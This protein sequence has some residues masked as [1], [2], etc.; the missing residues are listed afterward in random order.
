MA[1]A[2]KRPGVISDFILGSQDGIVNVL[3][4]ILGIGI[5]SN[6]FKILLVGGLAATF[7][8]SISMGAVAYTSTLA[9]RD[10]YLAELEREHNEMLTVPDME[11]EEIR[12]ILRRWGLEG[13]A[14]EAV[15]KHI[16][17]NPKAWLQIMMS[18]EL[19]LSP[20]AETQARRSGVL[21]LSSALV[22]SLIPLAPFLFLQNDVHT[23]IVASLVL[24]AATLFLIGWYKSKVTLGK[25]Y[26]SGLQMAIIGTV[27][28]LAGFLVGLLLSGGKP[29]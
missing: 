19:G 22:G 6:N 26:R 12:M 20:V 16:V 8:E 28:A 21:V 14:V 18:E 1:E 17:S 23:G 2:H 7:A 24:S 3:G 29:V 15:T 11:T 9:R 25:P 10:H 27:S 5:A 4:V 13:E